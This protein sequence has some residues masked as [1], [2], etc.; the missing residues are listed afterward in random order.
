MQQLHGQQ[1]VEGRNAETEDVVEVVQV[2]QV[3][4][5]QRGQSVPAVV[6]VEQIILN[7]NKY[8]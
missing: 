6:A 1:L 4:R 8:R 5:N 2:V 7:N 3:F